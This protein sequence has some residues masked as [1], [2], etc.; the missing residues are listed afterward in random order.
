[1]PL[2]LVAT[3]CHLLLCAALAVATLAPPFSAW[4]FVLATLLL[5]PL[6][7]VFPGLV[8][9]DPRIAQRAAVLMVPYVGGLSVEVVARAGASIVLNAAL[10]AAVLELGVVLAL[11]RRSHSRAARE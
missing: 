7:L 9:G 10:L 2:R 3:T 5:A 4:R 6:L 1:M 8:R 11:I